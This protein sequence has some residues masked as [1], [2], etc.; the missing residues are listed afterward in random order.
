MNEIV[1]YILNTIGTIAFAVSGAL[2]AISCGLDLFGVFF[3]GIVTACGGGILRDLIIGNTPPMIFADVTT[4][5]IAG[6]TALIVFIIAYARRQ[7]FKNISEKI[8]RINN[9]FDAIGLATFTVT[10]IEVVFSASLGAHSCLAIIMGLITGV[11]GGI[12]RDVLVS[13]P[14]Y[15]FRK[16]IYALASLAGAVVYYVLKVYV[17]VP[18]L[19]TAVAMSLIFAIRMLATK[20][21]W[22]L[23]K[24]KV[25]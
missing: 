6:A 13:K 17:C 3:L 20:Y 2:V 9:V 10:G 22:E 18:Y 11:G 14:P 4:L 7:R 19:D 24:V 25:D 12:F 5:I 15:I 23:P 16:H 1:T 21:K 8:E